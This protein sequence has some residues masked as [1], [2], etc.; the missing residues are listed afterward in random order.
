VRRWRTVAV[1]AAGVAIGVAIVATPAASHIGSVTH[2]WNHHIKP[3]ADARYDMPT[4]KKLETIRGTVGEQVISTGAGEWGFSASLPRQARVGLDDAHVTIDGVDEASGECPGT[5]D[6]PTAKPGY[7]CIYPYSVFNMT[8]NA[9]YIWGGGDE[10]RWGFT[11]SVDADGAGTSYWIANWAYKGTNGPAASR[12][13]ARTSSGCST[14][15]E[16]G[17]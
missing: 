12:P 2:L 8:P 3:K 15:G 14:T 17:C 16:G 11:A 1:L 4:V 5:S 6:N 9:G 13:V 10:S 7:V